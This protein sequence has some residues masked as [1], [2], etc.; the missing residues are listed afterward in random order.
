MRRAWSRWLL[1]AAAAVVT[2]G[3]L[4]WSMMPADRGVEELWETDGPAGHV[5]AGAW[6]ADDSNVMVDLRTGRTATLETPLSGVRYVGGDRLL[7]VTEEGVETAAAGRQPR[8]SRELGAGERVVPLA[9]NGET[10]VL[11]RCDREACLLEAISETGR[12]L[13]STPVIDGEPLEPAAGEVP[14]V[15]AIATGSGVSLVDPA[16]RYEL[17]LSGAQAVVTPG[18]VLVRY[19]AGSSC[20]TALYP[21]IG[22]D[23]DAAVPGPCEDLGPLL[24]LAPEPLLVEVHRGGLWPLSRDVATVSLPGGRTVTV[25]GEELEVLHLDGRHL[26]VRVGQRIRGYATGPEPA[27]G[28]EARG[29]RV[30]HL[31]D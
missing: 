27:Q 4:A 1:A 19:D 6:L 13:W 16:T 18:G 28:T 20:V 24:P 31:P 2:Y 5:V 9:V 17:V 8:W 29:S 15:V 25:T 7:V 3:V 26:T 22:R 21:T 11:H 23:D 14:A 12:T 30:G 10:T